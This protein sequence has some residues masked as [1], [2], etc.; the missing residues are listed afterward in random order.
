MKLSSRKNR[1]RTHIHH[2]PPARRRFIIKYLMNYRA[3]L[4]AEGQVPN[5]SKIIPYPRAEFH[6]SVDRNH[7]G[8]L[9]IGQR[10]ADA[11][12]ERSNRPGFMRKY[13]ARVDT[14]QIAGA[15]VRFPLCNK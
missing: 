3:E 8:W 1:C 9:V 14:E 10:M 12:Y 2:A 11:H 7:Y 13:L 4:K 5:Y 6:R 15:S